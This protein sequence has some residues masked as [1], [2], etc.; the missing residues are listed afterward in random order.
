MIFG[1]LGNVINF[2]PNYWITISGLSRY[3]FPVS[4]VVSLTRSNPSSIPN[5]PSPQPRAFVFPRATPFCLVE[6]R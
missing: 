5:V 2:S 1:K 6:F 4:S 3:P